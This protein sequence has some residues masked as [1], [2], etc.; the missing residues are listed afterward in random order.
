MDKIKLLS[1]ALANQIAAGEVVQRPASVVKE[2]LENSIDAGATQLT[3]IVKDSGKALIQVID[4][5]SGMSPADARMSFERHA[6]SKIRETLDLF[7]IRTMG[8]RGEALASIAAVAQVE[9][10][11]RREED[12]LG[13]LVRIEGSEVKE[14]EFIQTAPG[15]SIA[16]KNLFFNVPARR[17]FLKSNP[18]EMKHILEEFQRVALAHPEVQFTLFHNDIEILTLPAARLSKRITD[19]L[20]KSYRDQLAKCEIETDIVKVTG[21]VGK[22]QSAKKTR[23]DQYFFVNHR[24]IKSAYLHHAV[25]SAFESAIP[26]GTY[27][28]YT[29]FLEINP[30]NIDINIHPTKTE[31]KFDNEQA[32]YA[33]LRSAVKQSIGVYNL[34]PSIDFDADINLVHFS[35]PAPAER[36]AR[37]APA[38]VYR[39]SEMNKRDNLENWEK[40]FESF[41]S[42]V[43]TEAE[44]QQQVLFSS[45]LNC[46]EDIPDET[47]II[48]IHNTY[49]LTQVKSGLMIIHQR[50]AFERVLYEKYLKE[51]QSPQAHSQQL[52]FPKTVTLSALDYAL[53]L[54]IIDMIRNIGF[55]IEEFGTN[56]YL[57]NGVPSQFADEDE[58][59]L[60][61]SILESFKENENNRTPDKKETLAR[62]LAK[63]YAGRMSKTLHK[64]ELSNL[65]DQLFETAMPAISPDGKPVMTILALDKVGELIFN[66]GKLN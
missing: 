39:A 66:N 52:L 10:R 59:V 18:V 41:S 49:I 32:I 4:N 57:I 6:T 30:E 33:V 15:T 45:K 61:R 53:S 35:A 64:T 25:V 1:D 34:T 11:T 58:A 17:K 65:V 31:I 9:M 36:P 42:S 27:P 14:Q 37:P 44:P 62:T 51:I 55:S 20:D 50:H 43:N 19:T 46:T 60:F 26:E 40:M 47:Q 56:T 22:P 48:Q 8:F 63:K 13:T 23:G 54:D 12:E 38:T 3:L 21:Y 29:L 28:F 2:L 16:V 5:G 24:F 7:N